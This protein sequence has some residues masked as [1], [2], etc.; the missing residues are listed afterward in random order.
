MNTTHKTHTHTHTHTLSQV[1]ERL[2]QRKDDSE[3]RVRMRLE[4]YHDACAD[5]SEV[6]DRVL[7]VDGEKDAHELL[8][9]LI[10]FLQSV[11][12]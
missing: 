1:L 12:E 4:Q 5:L 11:D 2:T 10:E 9:E 3:E 6:F 8:P 7:E